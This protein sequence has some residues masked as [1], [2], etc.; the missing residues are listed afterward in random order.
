MRAHLFYNSHNS[1]KG[2]ISTEHAASEIWNRRTRTWPSLEPSAPAVPRACIQAAPQGWQAS[3]AT[4]KSAFFDFWANNDSKCDNPNRLARGRSQ[5]IV[6]FHKQSSTPNL[7]YL[8]A[9]MQGTFLLPA[10]ALTREGSPR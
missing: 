1:F 10:S 6:K 7:K 9:G 8:V 2:Q 4:G 5:A 3:C